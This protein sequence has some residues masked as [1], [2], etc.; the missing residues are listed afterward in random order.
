[1]NAMIRFVSVLGLVCVSSAMSCR[2]CAQTAS[3]PASASASLPATTAAPADPREL[4]AAIKALKA[5]GDD[6]ERKELA[7]TA[8]DSIRQLQALGKFD[9]ASWEDVVRG[10]A[11]SL[12][13]D[14]RDI[15]G[16]AASERYK[17]KTEAIR[18]LKAPALISL[19]GLLEPLGQAR[20]AQGIASA[21]LTESQDID[22]LAASELAKVLTL[23]QGAAEGQGLRDDRLRQGDGQAL[24]IDADDLVAVLA[25]QDAFAIELLLHPPAVVGNQLLRLLGADGV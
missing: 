21:W 7:A 5:E 22:S 4:S 18:Q 23:L 15:I 20:A 1:M 24:A 3:S 6:A 11:K 25:D 2:L 17:P 10:L 8:S 14:V 12:P 13:Q 19:M 9:P 16:Q